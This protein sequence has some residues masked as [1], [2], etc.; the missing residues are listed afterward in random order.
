[1]G[2]GGGAEN[3][4]A[5][6]DGH[7][8]VESGGR[9]GSYANGTFLEMMMSVTSVSTT[10]DSRSACYIMKPAW[11]SEANAKTEPLPSHHRHYVPNSKQNIQF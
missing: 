1:M 11:T 8:E 10:L 3:G 2:G 4:R 5:S 6:G 7:R 9:G